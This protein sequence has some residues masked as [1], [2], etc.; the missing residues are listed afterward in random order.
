MNTDKYS[1]SS[2]S[3]LLSTFLLLTSPIAAFSESCDKRL[4]SKRTVENSY[5]Q[6]IKSVQWDQKNEIP[7]KGILLNEY[8]SPD[9]SQSDKGWRCGDKI[10]KMGWNDF[11]PYAVKDKS[12]QWFQIVQVDKRGRPSRF[13]GK[14]G[15]E[16]GY[17]KISCK[18][19]NTKYNEI[20]EITYFAKVRK[21]DDESNPKYLPYNLKFKITSEKEYEVLPEANF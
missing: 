21:N 3:I 20:T 17:K 9:E 11:I 13:R 5:F 1:T 19:K 12:G 6:P 15:G 16:F 7:C 10:Y 4:K 8:G 14:S 2:L 18:K